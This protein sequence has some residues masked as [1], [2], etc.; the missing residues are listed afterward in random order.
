MARAFND[1]LRSKPVLICLALL[2]LSIAGLLCLRNNTNRIEFVQDSEGAG[3]NWTGFYYFIA[4]KKDDR[5]FELVERFCYHPTT[6]FFERPYVQR[7]TTRFRSLVPGTD[8]EFNPPTRTPDNSPGLFTDLPR[9]KNESIVLFYSNSD[10]HRRR[11]GDPES[12]FDLATWS[13]YEFVPQRHNVISTQMLFENAGAT[14]GKYAG[15]QAE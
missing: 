14:L 12:P 13:C 7:Y 1:E 3:Y 11:S 9:T 15:C 8:G 6:D 2:F 10:K 5:T 4:K